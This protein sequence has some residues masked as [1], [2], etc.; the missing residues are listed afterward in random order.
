[1]KE[2]KESGLK[3][4]SE[5]NVY[6]VRGI[7]TPS[8]H[9]GGYLLINTSKKQYLMHRIVA[10]TLIPNPDNKPTVNHKDGDKKNNH[11]S[12]LEWS[13]YTE[14][15]I[16]AYANGLNHSRDISGKNN[17][18]YGKT[19]S[20]ESKRKMSKSSKKLSSVQEKK[21]IA[22]METGRYK[23]NQLAGMFGVST[24]YISKLLK[25]PR[26]NEGRTQ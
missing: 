15:Q 20:I 3:V 4:D 24:A 18:M 5:G 16:H 23:Q 2:H 22:L 25:E 14:N 19:H 9:N 26:H 10:E 17:P 12:N 7:R 11:P 8:N 1:M 13:T 21:I 6:G